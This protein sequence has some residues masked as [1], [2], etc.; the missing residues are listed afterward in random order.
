MIFQRVLKGVPA[1]VLQEGSEPSDRVVQMMLDG[2]GISSNWWLNAP[3]RRI[4]PPEIAEKLTEE[5]L[6]EHLVNYSSVQ[7]K[8]PYISTTAGT[9]ERDAT[10]ASNLYF[11]PTYTALR[12]ATRDFTQDGYVF[13]AY[14]FLL[15][16]K[17]VE[18]EEFAEEVRDV[19]TYT[20]YYAWH[21]EGEIVAKVHIPARRIE[22]AEKYSHVGLKGK[23]DEG[24]VPEP[25]KVLVSPDVYCDPWRY[26]NVRGFPEET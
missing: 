11:P 15:G 25:E 5:A 13:Y 1:D 12:F 20:R 10:A 21:P 19:N 24:E 14:L 26:A 7:R 2:L 16:R 3:N 8:T 17:S 4:S 23:L 18:M 9:V 6:H 22:K